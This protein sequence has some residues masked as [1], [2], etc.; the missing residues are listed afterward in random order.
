MSSFSPWGG[1]GGPGEAFVKCGGKET[2]L[3]AH[4]GG[5]AKNCLFFCVHVSA[6]FGDSVSTKNVVST[7][8]LKRK[9]S[10]FGIIQHIRK[11]CTD[12]QGL[13]N[14]NW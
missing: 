10:N 5:F 13:A 12:T 1:L 8:A 3:G 4:E 2:R 6:Y 9:S 14:H 11:M 7:I